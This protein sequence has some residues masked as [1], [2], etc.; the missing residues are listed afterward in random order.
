MHLRLKDPNKKII[1]K[2]DGSLYKWAKR[3]H[4]TQKKFFVEP[5]KIR[6]E[7][8]IEDFILLNGFTKIKFEIDCDVFVEFDSVERCQ[9]SQDADLT[10]ITDQKFSRY[11]CKTLIEKIREQIIKCPRLYLCL[12]SCY[13]NI[14]NSYH[15]KTLNNNIHIAITQWLKTSLSELDIIDLSLDCIEYGES[16]TWVIPDKHYYIKTRAIQ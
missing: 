5:I 4:H 15:D 6:R 9:H 1:I 12:N 11:P 13:I 14:D 8:Q 10:V 7:K 16:F 3:W 2:S